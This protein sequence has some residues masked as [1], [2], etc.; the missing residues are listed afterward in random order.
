MT[1]LLGVEIGLLLE[2]IPPFDSDI[3]NGSYEMHFFRF[4]VCDVKCLSIGPFHVPGDVK[5]RNKLPLIYAWKTN[6]TY[7]KLKW[8]RPGRDVFGESD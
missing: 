5:G 1:R 2:V 4:P 6:T 7:F 8:N 3:E